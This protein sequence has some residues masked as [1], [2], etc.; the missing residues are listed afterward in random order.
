MKGYLI[1]DQLDC[2]GCS[3]CMNICPQSC[4]SMQPNKY[5]HI[6]PVVNET[7]CID[8]NL[9]VKICPQNK[10]TIKRQPI[11]AFAGWHNDQSEY[12]SSTSGGAAA[13]FAHTIIS[14][15]GVV[16][17]CAS[18]HGLLIH[19]VRVDTESELTRLKGS[20]YV[21]S[22]IGYTYKNILT[23]LKCGKAVLFI[24]TPCQVAGLKSFLRKDYESLYCV[25]L[26]CHGVPSQ[27]QLKKHI[28]R[29][30]GSD[31]DIVQFRKGNDMG[32]R[33]YSRSGDMSYYSNVWVNKFQDSYYGAFIDGYS[34]RES[35]YRCRYA[36]S[37]RASDITIGDFWGLSKEV[38]HDEI[39]GCSCILPITPKGLELAKKSNLKLI[40]RSVDEAISG[41]TQLRNPSSKS[42]RAKVFRF[43]HP[44]IGH[45]VAYKICEFDRIINYRLI[46]PI[47]RRIQI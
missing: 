43:L 4:I 37:K 31:A 39:N 38:N 33:I 27:T 24:G 35:C 46:K 19:H 32:L 17:G 42:Q 15:G 14:M 29:V 7:K 45:E 13:A 2:T 16:Y 3:T 30:V 25:D 40:K 18:D 28:K 9:C 5:G 23:D 34:Y 11:T 12:L 22:D 36:D 8:C 10:D 41:N 20:K 21:Q 6:Y 47:L 26:I 44:I 1:C